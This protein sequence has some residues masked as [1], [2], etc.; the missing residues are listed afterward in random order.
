MDLS[1]LITNLEAITEQLKQ[2]NYEDI[3]KKKHIE[4]VKK[5]NPI[6]D[7]FTVDTYWTHYKKECEYSKKTASQQRQILRRFD[8]NYQPEKHEAQLERE[9]KRNRQKYIDMGILKNK[10]ST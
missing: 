4:N 6:P 10:N 7:G 9:R 1:K 3:E 2:L 5:D 8:R